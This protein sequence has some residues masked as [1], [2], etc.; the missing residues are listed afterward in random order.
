MGLQRCV[1]AGA[2]CTCPQPT[3]QGRFSCLPHVTTRS[4]SSALVGWLPDGTLA[5]HGGLVA[6]S[7]HAPRGGPWLRLCPCLLSG[8]LGPG[9]LRLQR[10]FLLGPLRL[11]AIRLPGSCCCHL[12]TSSPG[13]L[14]ASAASGA[15]GGSAGVARSV[16]SQ[17]SRIRRGRGAH[18][19]PPRA[20]RRAH[21][22]CP[23]A[24]GVSIGG[25]LGNG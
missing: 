11:R 9:H 1:C 19:T 12:F 3:L 6:L 25:G 21:L 16:S 5:L 13:V 8:S 17:A 22:T 4:K 2:W 20:A 15:P 24:G 7:G 14:Y 10:S 23:W 18:G